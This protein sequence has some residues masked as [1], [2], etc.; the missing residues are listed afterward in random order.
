MIIRDLEH[1]EVVTE[2]PESKDVK[3]ASFFIQGLGNFSGQGAF[4]GGGGAGSNTIAFNSSIQNGLLAQ[5][6]SGT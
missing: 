1:L 5:L 3:G 2:S 6:N 4:A